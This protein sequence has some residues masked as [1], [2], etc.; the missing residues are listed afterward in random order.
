MKKMKNSMY[1]AP[2]SKFAELQKIKLF[3]S[4]SLQMDR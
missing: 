2:K 3:L 1:V 4:N